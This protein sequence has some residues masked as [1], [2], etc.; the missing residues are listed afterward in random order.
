V[1]LSLPFATSMF[2]QRRKFVEK[3]RIVCTG[4]RSR[5]VWFLYRSLRAAGDNRLLMEVARHWQFFDRMDC[6]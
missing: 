2:I 4:I 1:A 5:G 3:L 6:E